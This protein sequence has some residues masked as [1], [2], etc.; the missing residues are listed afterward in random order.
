MTISDDVTARTVSCDVFL[1]SRS[2]KRSFLL[3]APIFGGLRTRTGSVNQT[4]HVTS[5]DLVLNGRE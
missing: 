2:D 5:K 3:A 1:T 4:K